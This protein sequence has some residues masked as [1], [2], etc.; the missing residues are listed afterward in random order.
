[1]L[2]VEEQLK[3]Y[4]D[5]MGLCNGLSLENLIESH[6][7][8]RSLAMRDEAELRAERNKRIGA[9]VK[10]YIKD[11]DAGYILKQDVIDWLE[12]R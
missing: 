6:R 1:M 9:A 8:L 11:L 2:T 5:E 4:A 12:A 7:H 10:H 3:Q